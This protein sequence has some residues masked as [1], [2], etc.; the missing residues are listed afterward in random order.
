MTPTLVR[1]STAEK[2]LSLLL[3]FFINVFLIPAAPVSA[4]SVPIGQMLT[5][6]STSATKVETTLFNGDKVETLA[7]QH[8]AV[9]LRDACLLN[10]NP[11]SLAR[12]EQTSGAYRVNLERG[13]VLFASSQGSHQS[14]RIQAAGWDVLVP[15]G[16]S[17]KGRVL[18][19]RDKVLVSAL[20]GTLQI[21]DRQ[22]M[23]SLNEG[24]TAEIPIT[25]APKPGQGVPG[26]AA[27]VM[28]YP[29]DDTDVPSG[30]TYVIK[31]QLLDAAGNPVGVAGVPVTFTLR[32][33]TC[34]NGT[35][36][37]L[38]AQS[39]VTDN[40]GIAVVTMNVCT[41]RANADT[42][43]VSSP[44]LTGAATGN[45][46]TM[47]CGSTAV[48]TLPATAG[49]PA[50][51]VIYPTG[52]WDVPAGGI[53]VLKAQ[54]L[55]ATGNPVAASGVPVTFDL[56]PGV[57][58]NGAPTTFR[59]KSGKTTSQKTQI[60]M[61]DKNGVASIAVNVCAVRTN[62]DLASV[63]SPGLTG[64]TT[65]NMIAV[66]GCPVG[67]YYG[68]VAAAAGF[69]GLGTIAATAAIVGTTTGIIIYETTTPQASPVRPQ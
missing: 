30:G 3:I 58:K 65:A 47:K 62:V 42:I 1:R 12:I 53:F 23:H 8:A 56:A 44:G 39:A 27:K 20:Q 59:T 41:V 4:A 11:D 46:V 64:A 13:E 22:A 25:P 9:T 10:F 48:S 37:T 49:S 31:A 40:S 7:G 34:T 21:A 2:F 55:D 36:S 35:P 54:L 28:V 61:T 33:G 14:L 69:W 52:D 57:C 6:G 45:L 60:A 16:T 38:Q 26:G 50:K 15:S 43:S 17:S 63:S 51:L 67:A 68:A 32:P 29:T 5:T 18:T 19:G 24:E 66:K